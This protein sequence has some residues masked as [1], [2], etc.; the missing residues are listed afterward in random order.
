MNAFND[1]IL[2]E[3]LSKLNASQ[4]SI[5]T[6]SHWC[7]FHRKRADQVVQTWQKHF[8]SASQDRKLPL[9]YLANDILQNS[10]KKGP[11]F[12]QE[13]WQ[14]LP[15][16]LQDLV[17]VGPDSTRKSTLR[18]VDIWEERKVFGQRDEPLRKLLLGDLATAPPATS[19]AQ[20]DEQPTAASTAKVRG[21]LERIS[22]VYG[23]VQDASKDEDTAVRRCS[24]IINELQTIEKELN[25]LKSPANASEADERAV[26]LDR[27]D[28]KRH[29][30]QQ[31]CDQMAACERKRA[32]LVK[33]L[34]DA[35]RTQESKLERLRSQVEIARTQILCCL[36][37]FPLVSFPIPLMPAGACSAAAVAVLAICMRS[38][39]D[40]RRSCD[41]SRQPC[42]RGSGV[43]ARC[44][45]RPPPPS[46]RP[47][48][49]A[50]PFPPEPACPAPKLPHGRA[51]ACRALRFPRAAMRTTRAGASAGNGG[52]SASAARPQIDGSSGGGGGSSEWAGSVWT[53]QEIA[54]VT[55]GAVIRDCPPGRVCT[56]T[57]QLAP[58]DW[59]LALRGPRF[60]G[61]DFLE[62]AARRG[63]GGAIVMADGWGEKGDAGNA[64]NGGDA[65]EGG[66]GTESGNGKEGGCAEGGVSAEEGSREEKGATEPNVPPNLL[67]EG[68]QGGF[69]VMP[70]TLGA[71]QG[72]AREARRRFG[73]VV[74]GVTGSVGKTTARALT[75]LALS[76]LGAV[77]QT[78][79]NLNNHIGVPLTLLALPQSAAACVVEMGM[80]ARGEIA[81]LSSIAASTIR[82]LLNVGPAHIGDP[83]LGSL[84][85]IA[86]A[87]G[88]LLAD[89]REGDVCVVNGDD[90]LVLGLP[91]KGGVRRVTF[92]RSPSSDVQLLWV[93]AVD[94]GMAVEACIRNNLARRGGGVADAAAGGRGE[95][96]GA[97]SLSSK[98][99]GTDS[100][101]SVLSA[102][103]GAVRLNSDGDIDDTRG[104]HGD[105]SNLD[106]NGVCVR[107]NSPGLH[108]AD[109]SLAAAAVAV[110]AGVP[111]P[112][113]ARH[114]ALYEPIGMRMRA[115]RISTTVVAE[116]KSV[117]FLAPQR[118]SLSAKPLSIASPHQRLRP[119]RPVAAV[120]A[121]TA[122]AEDDSA[123]VPPPGCSRI[124]IELARPL[125][126]VLEERA[127]GI[128]VAEVARGGNAEATGLVDAGDQLI[129]TSAIVFDNSDSYG[130]VVVKKG[131]RIVRFNV[132]GE[133]FDTVMAAIGTH[134]S[135]L[136]VAI[137]LQKCKPL[138]RDP[139][140]S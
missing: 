24:A 95:E 7:I 22:S 55:G 72:L 133:K 100:S 3:K 92:G 132:R 37:Q 111:L 73:G 99:E 104:V 59:F 39:C 69:V 57:R 51:R 5:E 102:E 105:E 31:C 53:A 71:L 81:L 77:H 124:K 135:Y 66:G 8:A 61:A 16:A 137:E 54:D 63:C 13:F 82:L 6:L 40:G 118:P 131:M 115:G 140:T 10:R 42:D 134:P 25:A 38:L 30:L 9:L 89:A 119:A 129:A 43:V 67:P 127:G 79:G 48:A 70:D 109:N 12:I 126:M 19:A 84:E 112:M 87:K 20:A 76:P 50:A 101:S 125:G 123:D 86:E 64:G 36:P 1:A 14:V 138:T 58:G 74:V 56:D 98:E 28:T 107:I 128:F 17:R 88:E 34:T 65:L 44:L 15:S 90:S 75:A 33:L 96:G 114:M 49:L 78:Q 2:F 32:L 110:A 108:L 121:E 26:V 117:T 18:I 130:G 83:T 23:A 93:H 4:Q 80:S 116:A 60:D 46:A 27:L 120:A 103:A 47:P 113:A 106:S 91:I 97:E 136:K 21:P 122:S 45:M 68:W 139:T 41:S 29:V 94:G 62:E 85:A 35:L 52:E 11:E